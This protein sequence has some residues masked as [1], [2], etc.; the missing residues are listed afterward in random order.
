MS[1]EI[2]T[3]PISWR[4]NDALSGLRR[5]G[6]D[7]VYRLQPT[8][9]EYVMGTDD[10][11]SMRVVD[12]TGLASRIHCRVSREIGR[13]V[14][15]DLGSTNGVFVDGMRRERA[16][17]EPGMEVRIG[18][19]TWVA[20]SQRLA[21]LRSYLCRLIGWHPEALEPVDL[22]LRAVRMAA[23]R[24]AVLVL[25]GD[26]LA[27]I[28]ME[29]HRHV[30]GPDWPFILCDP[31]RRPSAGSP[32]NL[33]TGRDALEA[34]Q[35][36]SLCLWTARLPRD[37]SLLEDAFRQPNARAQLIVCAR[38]SAEAR[39]F[40]AAPITIPP[41]AARNSEIDRIVDGYVA[42]ARALLGADVLFTDATRKWVRANSAT[43]PDIQTATLRLLAVQHFGTLTAAAQWLGMSA[44]AL[45]VW[46]HRR[47]AW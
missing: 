19:V 23:A 5:W 43:V 31:R 2:D 4:I 45:H 10:G 11:C 46:I 18:G 28:A 30:V 24:R 9:S 13:W 41:L 32:P 39:P 25:C 26:D 42:E 47:S 1:T 12:P 29:L 14:V 3:S 16:L 36:G 40:V 22:A 35:G 38:T 6:T 34:A 20:E 17:L 27:P 37:F 7:E 8:S 15:E 44:S 21:A 33:I